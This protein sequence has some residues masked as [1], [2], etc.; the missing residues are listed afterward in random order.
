M[1]S[2]LKIIYD[3]VVGLQYGDEGKG[4]IAQKLALIPGLYQISARF[5]GGPN[6]GH[7]VF[8]EGKK[9]VLHVVPVGILARL[10]VNF[11]GPGCVVDPV[12]L[13]AEVE[14]I[15]ALGFDSKTIYLSELVHLITPYERKIDGEMNKRLGTTCKGI[16]PTYAHKAH[17]IGLRVVDVFYL[18]SSNGTEDYSDIEMLEQFIMSYP[19]SLMP[20]YRQD[21][22]SA[23][24]ESLKEWAEAVQWLGENISIAKANF[25]LSDGEARKIFSERKSVR[26]LAEGAQSV[27]LDNTYG[28]YPYVT[29]SNCMPSSAPAGIGLPGFA[30]KGRVIGVFKAY[31]TRVGSG[32]FDTELLYGSGDLI[33]EAG[34]E[35]G[36]TTGRKRRI[37][38][39]DL[40]DL[41]YACE[42]AGVD[43]LFMTKVDV[44]SP[45][46]T[47]SVSVCFSKGGGVATYKQFD[48]WDS[49]HI[50]RD[51]DITGSFRSFLDL[52][53]EH[54][55]IH[56]ETVSVGPNANDLVRTKPTPE[57]V[58]YR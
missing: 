30:T 45:G 47:G 28:T 17:R 51:T 29:S 4:K 18:L 41:Q 49:S 57:G 31:N 26:V 42:L 2:L 24:E 19:L 10:R 14:G 54:L 20:I 38:W 34:K 3:V 12:L 46:V 27:M 36:S 55:G 1:K 44:L 56:V 58:G 23:S 21:W 40:P 48:A 9:L 43:E 5:N 33:C 16:G 8:H 50:K 37:G 11:I 7:T 53:E 32:P 25:F 52:V 15:K 35:F 13:K 39:L 22:L 6:A